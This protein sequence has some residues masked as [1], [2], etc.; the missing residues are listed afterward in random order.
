MK[1]INTADFFAI[2]A[3]ETTD[4]STKNQMSLIIRFV[5]EGRLEER[6]WGFS[7]VSAMSGDFPVYHGH[8]SFNLFDVII[9]SYTFKKL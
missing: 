6:F 1:E 5:T 8:W 4:G 9:D 2:M 3:D 7:N